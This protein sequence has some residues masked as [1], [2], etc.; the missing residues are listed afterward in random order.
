MKFL[1]VMISILLL[2][3]VGEARR[4]KPQ[5]PALSQTFPFQEA[6]C[7]LNDQK[8]EV[9]LRF[10][11]K[12]SA[13]ENEVFG[14]PLVF[15]KTRAAHIIE[16]LTKP[17]GDFKFIKPEAESLCDKTQGYAMGEN[18]IGILYAHDNRPFQDLYEVAVWNLESDT[19]LGML[20]LGAVS[21]L[22]KV[23]NGF[24][25][26][27]MA[28][29]SDVDS[30]E[31]TSTF[32]RKMTATDKDLNAFNVVSVVGS[33]LEIQND[34]DLSY[35]NSEWKKY[36]KDK[37]EYLR[38]SGWDSSKKKFKKQIVYEASYFNRSESDIQEL[39]IAMTDKRGGNIEKSDWRCLKEKH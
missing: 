11:T 15:L 12:V 3:N 8:V 26:S 29:R 35:E 28:Q 6:Q 27:K 2:V 36:F 37:E 16:P 32:G 10:N 23:K 38:A 25:F 39:C 7:S 9:L 13:Q 4:K 21:H 24:A 31:M 22:L 5:G 18:L 20:Q 33:H 30:L 14:A 19:F 1:W 34:P 17:P